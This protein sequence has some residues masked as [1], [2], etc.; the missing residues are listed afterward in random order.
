MVKEMTHNGDP[1]EVEMEYSST[2]RGDPIRAKAKG[3]ARLT[4][5]QRSQSSLAKAQ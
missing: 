3:K 4:K 5:A 2:G 1:I